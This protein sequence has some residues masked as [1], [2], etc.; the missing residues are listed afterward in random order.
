[1]KP[2]RLLLI[3]LGVFL[4][5]VLVAGGVALVPAVQRWAVLRVV[6]GTPGLK[7]EAA[8]VAAG[9]SRISL[10]GVKLEKNGLTVELGQLDADYSLWSLAFS[11]RL[12][13]GRL[14]GRGL[15]VDASRISRPKAGAAAA[16]VPAAA[17]GLLGQVELPF[18]LV[19]GD[20]L[21]EGRVLLPG[22]AGSPPVAVEYKVTGGQLA[23]GQEG[24]L[25][26][27]TTLK[28]PAAEAHVATLRATVTLRLRETDHRT[29]GR[30]GLTAVVDAEGR[31][32]SGQ[33]QLK[34]TAALEETSAGESYELSVDTLIGGVAGNLLTVHAVLPA[35]G[36]EYAG[37][38]K[39]LAH[40]AQVEPFFLGA[41]LPEFNARG[42]GRFA[43]NPSTAAASLQGGLA[44]DVSGLETLEPAWRALG[45][46]KIAAQFDLAEADGVA[47]LNELKVSLAGEA[48]VLELSAARA[49]EINFKERRLQ[50]GG[51][52]PGEALTLTLHGLPLAWVRPF[53]HTADV[54]GGMITGQLAITGEA[55]RVL[56]RAVQPL[57]V[58]QLNVVQA[59][60]PL[61]I[62]ADVTLGFEAVLTAKELTAVV[63]DFTLQT[64]AGDTLSAQARV[65]LPVGPDPS[66]SVVAKYAADLPTLLA[67]WLPLGRVKAAG[68]ADFTLA[69]E[70]L[71]LHQLRA[72]VTD[73]AGHDLCK[74]AALRPFTFDLAT[75][76]AEVAGTVGAVELL[77]VTLDR[78]PL[79][80]LPL[81]LPGT[82]LGGVVT[83]GELV[84][85][86]DG[87]KLTVRSPAAFKL[88]EVSLTEQRQ[89]A[90]AGLSFEAR[91]VFELAGGANARFQTGDITVRNA[92][93]DLLLTAK[94]EATH[95]PGTGLQGALSF[96]LEVPALATQ[97][98][99]AGAQAVS[100]GRASGEVRVALGSARQ[101]EARL[102]VNGLVAAGTGATLPVA[103]L[104]F[105][106]VA[107]A[108]G[109]FSV[110]APLLLDRGGQRSDLNFSLDLTPAGRGFAISGGLT[111]EH[112]ELAD[113]L[114]VL[115]VFAAP[116]TAAGAKP[117]ETVAAAPAP[118]VAD[119]APPWSHFTGRLGLD[120]KYV[121]RGADWAMTG[122]TGQVVIESADVTLQKLEA[123]FGEKGRF[124]AKALLSF[125]KGASPYE[126]TG[127]FALTEFD[128][129]KLF[130]ALEPAK[131]PTVEGVFT[132]AGN[133]TGTGET[134]SRT[135]E[136]S[137][138]SFELTSRAGVFRGLQR[139]TNKVSMATKAV[140]L[141]G[142]LFGSSKVVE[143]VAGSAYV[144]DQ[145][146]QALGEFNYDQLSVKLTR[147]ESLNVALEDISLVAPEIRLVGKGTVTYAADKPLL[148]QPLKA[149]LALAARGKIEEQLGKLRALSGARDEL[150]YAKAKE[151]VTFGGTLLRPDPTA[152]FAR[153]AAS[154]LTDLLTPDN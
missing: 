111:G 53:V 6:R 37:E 15:L 86:L 84:L 137:R 55:D 99:F 127:N 48:P 77:R 10:A 49:A 95:A 151:A 85:A 46:V 132:V 78:M 25:V 13:V 113:V 133:F 129:G 100:A 126:L 107:Q 112:V 114:A 57:R 120:V 1:M 144:V 134:L 101:I 38:W 71:E 30:V 19:L 136:R 90:L 150:D 147:D 119:I 142:S 44:A 18:E 29:F 135:L 21:L 152:Y 17:P 131:P 51:A 79:A 94:G 76:R 16:G 69:G 81:T 35:G 8:T 83:Q 148:E 24:T 98:I 115:G 58:G 61:L 31:N 80:A 88:A 50:V 59:G 97:P 102:T 108:D 104:S 75:R 42:E 124:A 67:P 138:G 11:R 2:A 92:A 33:E 118:L 110:Q 105:R 60:V 66:V 54:S 9:L 149:S 140:D 82:K 116:A 27:A 63:S 36:K 146:A 12:A 128:A 109:R 70:K 87:D 41:A 64:P 103:N 153:L 122:L 68:E 89:P 123:A 65:A 34:A 40:T 72:G 14:T 125:T 91:P 32:L 96:T 26:L 130:K 43:F 93:G 22:S 117:A 106:A 23:P 121:V 20:C 5:L 47:R 139:T 3:I 143:K 56:L 4:A 7:F 141:V 73:V 74:V 52:A 39:V 28:N 45:P 62:K 145:L 154:K